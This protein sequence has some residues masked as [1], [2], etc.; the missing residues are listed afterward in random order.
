MSEHNVSRWS[1]LGSGGS[2]LHG[3][4]RV[5]S[6]EHL[7]EYRVLIVQMRLSCVGDEELL[8]KSVIN[9]VVRMHS[10]CDPLVLTP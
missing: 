1:V 5:P 3:V 2:P 10:T 6:V 9:A 8:I 7:P 4:Q